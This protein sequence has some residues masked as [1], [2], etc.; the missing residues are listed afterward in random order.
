[1]ARTNKFEAP[2]T[3]EPLTGTLIRRYN[4][5]LAEF[6]AAKEKLLSTENALKAEV[7]VGYM[8]PVKTQGQ[9]YEVKCVT[10]EEMILDRK[11]LE[12]I[13]TPKQIKAVSKKRTR[14]LFSVKEVTGEYVAAE[15]AA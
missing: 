4:A 9:W 1:M 10:S 7:G 13:L 11:A 3:R 2:L 8:L 14:V 15:Y 12:E 5:A 6:K